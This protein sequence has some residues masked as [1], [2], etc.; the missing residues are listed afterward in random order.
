MKRGLRSR[1]SKYGD[2]EFAFF[3][4][5]GFLKGAGYTDAALD[6]PIVGILSTASDFNPCHATAG[7]LADRIAAGVREAGGLP[8]VFPT[9][10]IH[11]SFSYPNSMLLRNLMSMDTE[12][13]LK[14]L[15]LD[16][17]VLIGGC[18]KTIPAEIMGAISAD[19][20]TMIIPVGPMLAGHH[21]GRVLG[22]CTD[23]R[24]LWGSFRAGEIDQVE[25]DRAHDHLMPTAGTC[26]VMGTASTMAAI[27]ETL[28]FSLPGTST[29]PAVSSERMRLAHATGMHAVTMAKDGSPRP[30]EFLTPASFRNASA[31]LQAT[32]GSTNGVVHLAAMAGRAGIRYDLDELDQLGRDVP[33]LI[34]LKPAGQHFAEHFHAA[35]SVP[36]LWRRMRDYLDLSQKTVTGETLGEIVDRWPAWTDDEIIRPLDRPVVEGDAIA[37]LRGSLAP[38]GAVIKL[39]AAT[40]KLCQHEGTAVVFSS[41]ADLEKRIDDPNLDVTPD[42]VLVLQNAGPIGAP[43]M[44]ESGALPIPKKLATKGVKDM[45]RIS[46]ARMSGTAFGTVVLHVA[47]EAAAGGPLGLVRDGDRIRLD[48]AGRKLDLLVEP[49]E[50]ARRKAEWKPLAQPKRG[51]GRLYHDHVMQS[52]EGADFDF[53]RGEEA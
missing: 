47:P 20:P 30:S 45:V 50:L 13:M 14:A 42:S 22:A 27:A 17:A 41:V 46:D 6:K 7:Q 49:A 34:N 24:R 10:S 18:D 43:G 26:M 28:G 38:D 52:N 4:R 32:S 21:E 33:V 36:A 16:A 44:P 37:V 31:V 48:S 2:E 11:E 53:L 39:S 25:L 40:P 3:L 15:P 12:E 23:C 35:G 9:I 51:Y 19:M 8:F 1:L 5:R 29:A